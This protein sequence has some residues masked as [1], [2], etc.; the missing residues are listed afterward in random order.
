MLTRTRRRRLAMG[1]M[2]LLG[3]RPMGF[4]L[5]YRYAAEVEAG[6]YPALEPLFA[7]ADERMA[8][9]FDQI[10][11]V[12]DDFLGLGGPPPEP[13]F[14]QGWFPRLDAAVAY[15]LVRW[16]QPARIVEIGSGHSTRFLA[17]AIRDEG[18]RESQ[19]IAVDPAP[20]ASL[21]GL[22]VGWHRSVVQEMPTALVRNLGP[23]DFLVI[24]SSHLAMPGSDL[25]HVVGQLLPA[26]APGVLVHFHDIFLPDSYPESW[27]WRGYNE[28]T[29]IAA[30]LQGGG[31]ELLFASHYAASR[32]DERLRRSVVADL[33]LANAELESS[34]WLRKR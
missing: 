27:A 1:L 16:L 7:E 24:D 32:H 12:G 15:A 28:Q 23:D 20:R 21:T 4:F 29:V 18:L 33:P 30:L 34:L 19:L 8:E 13:R 22:E 5:P 3:P 31:Y 17:A 10:D 9:I 11:R 14:D 6:D 25:D 26:L 2:T